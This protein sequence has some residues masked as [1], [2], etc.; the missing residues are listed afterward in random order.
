MRGAVIRRHLRGQIQWQ[1]ELIRKR[2][3]HGNQPSERKKLIENA[4]SPGEATMRTAV[5]RRH[6]RGQIQWQIELMRQKDNARQ[7][8]E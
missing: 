4:K 1:I 6:L 8:A 3:A 5:K 7:P 2:T